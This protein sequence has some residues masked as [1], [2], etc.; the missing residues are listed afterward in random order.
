M[1]AVH[2]ELLKHLPVVVIMV[3]LCWGI[4]ELRKLRI[5]LTD[6]KPLLQNFNSTLTSASAKFDDINHK[7]FDNYPFFKDVNELM[8][9]TNKIIK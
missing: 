5:E 4:I 7:K 8:V 2:E 9:K 6:Y 3:P 1:N